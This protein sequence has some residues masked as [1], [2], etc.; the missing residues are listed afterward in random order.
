MVGTG[1]YGFSGDGGPGT[2]AALKGATGVAV[3]GAG[4]VFIADTYNYRVRKL[5]PEGTVT[6]VAGVGSGLVGGSR[7]DGAMALR[8]RVEEPTAVAVDGGGN[9]SSGSAMGARAGY[10]G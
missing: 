9:L 1:Q 5:D 3:D 6:T 8:S 7:D 10:V 2:S 4:N